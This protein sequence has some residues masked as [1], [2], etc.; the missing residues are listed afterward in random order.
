MVPK[1]FGQYLLEKGIVTKEQ[2]LSAI[3]Y[4]KTKVLKLGEIAVREGFLTEE[5]ALKI[6]EQQKVKDMFFGELALQMGLLTQEQV[7]KLINLQES[8][9][10][11][12][13]EAL[14]QLNY[15]TK[16]QLQEELGKFKEEQKDVE[17]IK[18]KVPEW[19]RKTDIVSLS[20]DITQ[21]LFR[22]VID[23]RVKYGTAIR[24]KEIKN[25]HIITS[26]S[27]AGD[28]NFDYILNMPEELSLITAKGL[29]RKAN[30]KLDEE[31]I[32]D[33]VGEFA[34]VV[35]GNI[36]GKILEKGYKCEIAP[37]K[38]YYASKKEKLEIS[39]DDERKF[40]IFPSVSTE[41]KFES[42]LLI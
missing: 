23:L 37:P 10:I 33:A 7:K 39:R 14:V 28:E 17:E 1:F 36:K 22:R 11:Y 41:G 35:C 12:L 4:Q 13:G 40:T 20:M 19:E 29:Y 25:L 32:L 34:N 31:T 18:I 3:H 27:F 21:K 30:I 5:Q 9:H 26:I 2:L 42:I 6:N 15:I 8:S 16:A 38:N 24:A